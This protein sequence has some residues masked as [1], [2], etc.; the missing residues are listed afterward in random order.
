MTPLAR[1]AVLAVALA[2]SLLIQI[3]LLGPELL[4]PIMRTVIGGFVLGGLFG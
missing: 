3:Y 4:S 1:Y 2:G